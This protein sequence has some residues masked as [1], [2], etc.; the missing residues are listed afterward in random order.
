MLRPTAVLVLL[1]SFY[2]PSFGWEPKGHRVVADVATHHLSAA[3]RRQVTLLLGSDDLASISTWAD[4]IRNER[5]ETFGWH[6]VDIPWNAAGFDEARDCFRSAGKHASED[7]HNCVVERIEIF[8]RTLADQHASTADRAEAL[9]FLG[10]FVA[11]V[12]Q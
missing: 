9:K 8:A 11:Y 6:F 12:H 2:V 1:L 7:H 5:P 3:V 10:H 4:E